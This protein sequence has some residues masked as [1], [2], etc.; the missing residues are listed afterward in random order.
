MDQD[1]LD[2]LGKS[3]GRHCYVPEVLSSAINWSKEVQE[4]C[5]KRSL[6]LWQ[7]NNWCRIFLGDVTRL[8]A[9]LASFDSLNDV[10]GQSWPKTIEFF[11]FCV[12]L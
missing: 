1:Q 7:R 6:V 11:V 5:S 4:Y 10:I 8:L 2:Q 12:L 3:A 9:Y